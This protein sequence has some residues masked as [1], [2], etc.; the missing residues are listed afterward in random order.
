MVVEEG[1]RS[2][3]RERELRIYQAANALLLHFGYDKTTVSDI[4][5]EAGISKGAIY[6]HFS[7]KDALVE[8][9]IKHEMLAYTSRM[10]D[11]LEQDETNWTFIGLYQHSL[12]A[13]PEHPLVQ[14][15]IR[16]D[17]HVFGNYLTKSAH[18]FM[19]IKR[20]ERLPFLQQMQAVGALRKD[21]NMSVVAF[22][23][24]C[25]GYGMLHAS[26]FLGN[27]EMPDIEA[28]VN[29]M[30]EMLERYLMPEDG[31]NFEEGRKIILNIIRSYRDELKKTGRME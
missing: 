1:Q 30:G 18:D 21:V 3:N 9:L 15:I 2:E 28:L 29:E 10:L 6:L 14:A 11:S 5:R 26:E 16:G 13:L 19:E 8:A 4:A 20:E 25:F 27:N 12:L 22:I 24:D 17:K 31:G 23:L 7:S